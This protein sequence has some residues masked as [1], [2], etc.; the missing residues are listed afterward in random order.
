[1]EHI[2]F[3]KKRIELHEEIDLT[4]DESILNRAWLIRSSDDDGGL[5]D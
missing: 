3:T 4:D 1:M 2:D 5:Y